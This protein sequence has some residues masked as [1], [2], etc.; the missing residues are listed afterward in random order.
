MIAKH[1]LAGVLVLAGVSATVGCG[2]QNGEQIKATAASA[3]EQSKKL[4]QGAAES[5]QPVGSGGMIL[6]EALAEI[7]K[8]DAAKAKAL[9]ADV[10]AMM[11]ASKPEDVKAK[12]KELLGKL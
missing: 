11:N 6:T 8:T 2:S 4:L 9:Q 12:A 3:I 10:D 7:E 1:L 5:G